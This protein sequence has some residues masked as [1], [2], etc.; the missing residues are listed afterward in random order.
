MQWTYLQVLANIN[1]K[2]LRISTSDN[3]TL[4]IAW[5]SS[6]HTTPAKSSIGA[7][8]EVDVRTEI[9]GHHTMD[10]AV[11]RMASIKPD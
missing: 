2:M 10:D 11:R 5:S 8:M 3:R 6:S 4:L 7:K 9:D 1:S